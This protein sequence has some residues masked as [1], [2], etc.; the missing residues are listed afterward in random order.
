LVP[1]LTPI[2]AVYVAIVLGWFFLFGV[3]VNDQIK[4]RLICKN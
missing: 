4:K 1:M 3:L 2:P